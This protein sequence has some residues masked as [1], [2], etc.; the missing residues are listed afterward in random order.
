[1]KQKGIYFDVTGYRY[2]MPEVAENDRKATGGKYS[3]IPIFEK[4]FENALQRG[5]KIAFGTGVD[6]TADDPRSSGPLHHGTQGVEFT[7]L[8]NHHMTPAEALQSATI[9]DASM[10]G[11]QDQIGSITP[12]KYADL[13]AVAGDPLSDITE[14]IRVKFVMKGGR[15]VR[16][17]FSSPT[18]H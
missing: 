8:V 3:I 7:W 17:D 14:M 2:T 18:T 15:V 12:G 5:V 9:V 6:G 1:M 11:L 10:L 13:I 4:D 16:D